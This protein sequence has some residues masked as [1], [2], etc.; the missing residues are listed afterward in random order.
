MLIKPLC[1][2]KDG[3][4]RCSTCV[5]VFACWEFNHLIFLKLRKKELLADLRKFTKWQIFPVKM[6]LV[7]FWLKIVVILRICSAL[8]AVFSISAWE[9]SQDSTRNSPKLVDSESLRPIENSFKLKR[10]YRFV[11]GESLVSNFNKAGHTNVF[12]LFQKCKLIVPVT[13]IIAGIFVFSLDLITQHATTK[14]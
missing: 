7:D 12:D 4:P 9:K 2:G 1:R 13:C 10:R 5:L 14:K 11:A 8:K 3:R 6:V